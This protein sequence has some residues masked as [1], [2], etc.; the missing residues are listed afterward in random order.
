MLA[1]LANVF[2]VTVLLAITAVWVA[3]AAPS[4][5]LVAVAWCV[6]HVGR[7]K[8]LD[9]LDGIALAPSAETT[10]RM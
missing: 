7:L 5:W 8:V 2:L 4:V 6:V 3:T 9:G 1:L 10:G